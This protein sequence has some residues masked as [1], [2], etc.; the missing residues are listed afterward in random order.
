M[1]DCKTL[2]HYYLGG[3]ELEGDKPAT[4]AQPSLSPQACEGIQSF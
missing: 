4:T 3:I 2:K 1:M